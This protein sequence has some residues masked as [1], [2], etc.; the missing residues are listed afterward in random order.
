MAKKLYMVFG[1]QN[2]KKLTVSLAEP[3]D[4]L[5]QEDVAPVMTACVTKQA[6]KVGTNVV[7]SALDAYIREVTDTDVFNPATG[8]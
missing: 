8:G 1:L 4:D 2:D 6:F 5:S 7:V 3:K